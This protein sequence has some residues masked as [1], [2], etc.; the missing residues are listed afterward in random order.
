[1]SRAEWYI[2]SSVASLKGKSR[3]LTAETRQVEKV[4]EEE[5]RILKDKE[6]SELGISRYNVR[7]IRKSRNV[8]NTVARDRRN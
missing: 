5:K 2:I 1:M 4:D 8:L 6:I 7:N 3:K